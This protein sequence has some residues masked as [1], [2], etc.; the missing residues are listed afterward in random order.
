VSALHIALATALATQVSGAV[1]PS[2]DAETGRFTITTAN[3]VAQQ[4]FDQG[5]RLVYASNYP[6]AERSFR[7]ARRIDP[8]CAMCYWGEALALG[9]NTERSMSAANDSA[10]QAAIRKATLHAHRVSSH[11]R[12]YIRALARRYGSDAIATRQ[13]RDSAYARAMGEIVRAFPADANAAVL[14]A[15]AQLLLSPGP[16]RSGAQAAPTVSFRTALAP[17][18][19]ALRLTPEAPGRVPTP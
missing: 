12:A 10:A 8:T 5:L 14:L 19:A 11:E 18:E 7:T 16:R 13:A 4:R 17:L 15:D 6:E 3:P 1:P 9:P 2:I